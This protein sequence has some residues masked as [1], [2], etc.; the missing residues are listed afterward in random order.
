MGIAYLF[1]H[2]C[3]DGPTPFCKNT[4][5]SNPHNLWGAGKVPVNKNFLQLIAQLNG[6]F[7]LDFCIVYGILWE[8][9]INII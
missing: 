4:Q 6:S 8:H 2:L 3:R 5:H 9:A 7:W 1:L